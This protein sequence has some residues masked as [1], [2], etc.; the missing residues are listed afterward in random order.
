M[1]FTGSGRVPMLALAVAFSTGLLG[2]H[3][4]AM[5]RRRQPARMAARRRVICTS[6]AISS[7]SRTSCP[8]T[9]D[10]GC[11]RSYTEKG[12]VGLYLVDT[13]AKTAKPV[14]LSLAAKP[15]PLYRRVQC[16]GT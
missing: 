12:G 15:D 3:G 1:N 8:S 4:L 2:A 10:A 9:V 14:T 6:S 7:V 5:A 13:R 11:G 16:T